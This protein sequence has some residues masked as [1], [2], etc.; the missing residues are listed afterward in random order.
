[1]LSDHGMSQSIS[2]YANR[3]LCEKGLLK[4]IG[5]R[6]KAAFRITK[7]SLKGFLEKVGIRINHLPN[8]N[9]PVVKRRAL[10]MPEEVD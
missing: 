10:P 8:L 9:I 3:W 2:F 4:T 6:R 7:I 1:M 5:D